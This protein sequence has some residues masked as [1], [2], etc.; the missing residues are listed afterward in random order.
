VIWAI[1]G[2][3]TVNCLIAILMYLGRSGER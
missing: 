1:M 2:W 3:I